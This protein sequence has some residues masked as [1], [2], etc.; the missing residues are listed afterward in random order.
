MTITGPSGHRTLSNIPCLDS[1]TP[2]ELKELQV[3]LGNSYF[4]KL[5]KDSIFTKRHSAWLTCAL[6]TITNKAPPKDICL[7]WSHT[8]DQIITE[9]FQK[10]CD[11]KNLA[12]FALGKLGA[13]ELNLSS[14]VDLIFVCKELTEATVKQVRSFQNFL[15]QQTELGFLFRCDLE[16]RPGGKSAPIAST[17]DQFLDYYGNYGETWERIA[18]VR[19]RFVCGNIEVKNEISPFLKKFIYRKHLDFALFEDLKSLREKIQK[20]VKVDSESIHLKLVPGG[21]RDIE[22]FINSLQVIHGGKNPQ[23]QV[24]NTDTAFERIL[25]E[26]ILPDHEL[27]F[28]KELYWRLRFLE[29]FVQAQH[30][31][32]THSIKKVGQYPAPVQSAL[33]KIEK[34]LLESS[35]IV[36]GLLGNID[37]PTLNDL[38]NEFQQAL[39]IPILSRHKERDQ[40]TRDVF[41][42]KFS[43]ALDKT[44]GDRRLAI[45]LL[46]EFITAVRAK[47][48]LFSLLAREP[49]L[50]EDLAWLFGSSPYLARILCLRP[51]LLD[52]FVYRTQHL[53][54][55]EIDILLEQLL[56]KRLLGEII[57]G[58]EFLKNRNVVSLFNN[59]TT[60]TD[61]IVSEVSNAVGANELKILALGKWGGEELGFRSD[62]D[63]LFVTNTEPEEKHFKLARRLISRLTE[64]HKG[65]SLF[66]IDMRLKPSGQG[67][68]MIVSEKSL[69]EYIQKMS[70]P[71][72]R[73]AYLKCRGLHWSA[74]KI[75]EACY[76]QPISPAEM[77]ELNSIRQK[78]IKPSDSDLKYREGGMLD[79]ELSIQ[80]Y[81]LKNQLMAPGPSTLNMFEVVPGFEKLKMN[82]LELRK[83]EQLS[84]LLS[85]VTDFDLRCLFRENLEYLNQ[86]DPRRTSS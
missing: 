67:G 73:Q 18:M 71:W 5:N 19:C 58:T 9:V 24:T 64:P 28:F 86:L 83:I 45:T 22:L 65:G 16:L 23:L 70:K 76:A 33:I 32:Q 49:K 17:V 42:S 38:G 4:L 84:H 50:A 26:K 74:K 44:S 66:S 68:P 82:Y 11:T 31:Q 47:S 40:K 39:D 69:T 37:R 35:R 61:E 15:S 52:S 53:Q 3:P 78:L 62:L 79:I 14:D 81:L 63:F 34:D 20:A 56:E 60:M 12:V 10:F 1:Y 41:I 59:L 72:E 25:A 43:E 75:T 2:A 48:G 85:T 29:N 55:D 7:Y 27:R 13:E 6:A 21:I 51:E 77:T 46:N 30:D 54:R 36:A 57:Q 8:A 80:T